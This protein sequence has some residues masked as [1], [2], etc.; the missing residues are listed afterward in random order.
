[1]KNPN[2][3]LVRWIVRLEDYTYEIE[4]KKGKENTAPDALSRMY[5]INEIVKNPGHPME[6]KAI[7]DENDDQ[8]VESITNNEGLSDGETQPIAE[9]LRRK[10]PKN[11]GERA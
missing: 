6:S 4:Y 2:S 3:R 10:E 7:R 5:P 9:R 11:E 8:A 1:M